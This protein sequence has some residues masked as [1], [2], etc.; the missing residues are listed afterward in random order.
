MSGLPAAA[1]ATQNTPNTCWK[2]TVHY[3]SD[4]ANFIRLLSA[5]SELHSTDSC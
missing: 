1:P 3:L 2:G 5:V 4:F